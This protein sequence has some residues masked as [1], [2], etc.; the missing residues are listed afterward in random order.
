MFCENCGKEVM[1]ND[2]FC[3]E[4]GKE[5][6]VPYSGQVNPRKQEKKRKTG[7]SHPQP[8]I[9]MPNKSSVLGYG[10]NFGHFCMLIAYAAEIISL[11]L[12]NKSAL[13]DKINVITVEG[14][15]MFD[16]LKQLLVGLI[17]PLFEELDDELIIQLCTI[18]VIFYCVL[19][20][21]ACIQL[22]TGGKLGS[23]TIHICMIGYTVYQ[24]NQKEDYLGVTYA[25]GTGY[26]LYLIGGIALLVSAVFAFMISNNERH[27]TSNKNHS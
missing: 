22:E 25:K 1:D 21:L 11:F 6:P 16:F 2:R 17:T 20:L 13:F 9:I 23:A 10:Y 24:F 26:W 14:I 8:F 27:R 7:Q 4:C 3:P 18:L 19:L 12:P 5:I 15:T